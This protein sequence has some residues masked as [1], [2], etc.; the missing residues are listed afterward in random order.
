MREYLQRIRHIMRWGEFHR[1]RWE[2]E[3]L[4]AQRYHDTIRDMPELSDLALSPGGVAAGYSLLYILVRVLRHS[5]ADSVLEI[6]LGQSS[7]LIDRWQKAH[8]PLARHVILEGDQGWISEFQRMIPLQAEIRY[9]RPAPGKVRMTDLTSPSVLEENQKSSYDVYL[10]DGPRGRQHY[11]R[12]D[13][14]LMAQ[15]WASDKE[16]VVILD[17]YDRW[18]ERQTGAELIRI[19]QK[20]GINVTHRVINGLSDQLVIFTSKFNICQTF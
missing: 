9:F 13:I 8:L 14:C 1:N 19:C 4:W 20:N 16:F 15:Q 6:G 7:V 11:S 17:D 5:G 18:G 2:K 12:Y 10:V 3:L